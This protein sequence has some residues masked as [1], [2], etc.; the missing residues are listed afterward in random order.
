MWLVD[1]SFPYVLCPYAK[2]P[3]A[4]VVPYRISPA[5]ASFVFQLIVID[6][7]VSFMTETFEKREPLTGC[8]VGEVEVAVFGVVVIVPGVV[9][10]VVV[11]E[12]DVVVC[13]VEPEGIVEETVV[14][15]DDGTEG[16]VV[17]V[18][19]TTGRAGFVVDVVP[20]VEVAD[21]GTT[22]SVGVAM[23]K[24]LVGKDGGKPGAG[25]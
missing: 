11:A 4:L 7:S 15:E 25:V 3:Y 24:V 18:G 6:V 21:N 22:G 16:V 23:G 1:G 8:V 5:T 19:E 13:G 10:V 17:A 2:L 20:K 9:E 12:V 14:G